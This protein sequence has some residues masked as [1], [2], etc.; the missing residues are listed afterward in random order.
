MANDQPYPDSVAR[1]CLALTRAGLLPSIT[2]H[3]QSTRTALEAAQACGCEVGQI[4]KSLI[5]VS[6]DTGA[7]VLLLVAGDNRVH[8]RRAGRAIGEA[9]GRADVELVRRATGF[10]IG[11]VSPFGHPAPIRTYADE[12]FARFDRLWAAA[13]TPN[14]VFAIAPDDLFRAT[15]ATIISVT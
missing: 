3:A 5:F 6:R 9:I 15:G 10:A 8:E 11:G 4:V 14:H 1:V 2:H 12:T 13:G 7:P